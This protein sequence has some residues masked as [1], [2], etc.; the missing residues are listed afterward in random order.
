[1]YLITPETQFIH[2]QGEGVL[3]SRVSA[4]RT[5][6]VKPR[7]GFMASRDKSIQAPNELLTIKGNQVYVFNQADPA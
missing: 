5:A 2:F 7:D 4:A 6:A 1:M 3:F